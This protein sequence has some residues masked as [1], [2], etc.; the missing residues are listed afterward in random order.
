MEAVLSRPG[1]GLVFEIETESTSGM[2]E[3][4]VD[5]AEPV[6]RATELAAKQRMHT[7]SSGD[8]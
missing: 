7:F 1:R 3:E 8:G 2:P 4:V 6:E 5:G